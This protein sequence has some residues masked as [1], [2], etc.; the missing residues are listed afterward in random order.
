VLR[1]HHVIQLATIF[2]PHLL[3]THTGGFT[4]KELVKNFQKPSQ[5][6]FG[7]IQHP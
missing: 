7:I 5:P 6:N 2:S 1:I 3:V 4:M